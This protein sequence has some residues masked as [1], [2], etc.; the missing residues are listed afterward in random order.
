MDV[1]DNFAVDPITV[2]TVGLLVSHFCDTNMKS[3][4]SV[5]PY[6]VMRGNH[7]VYGKLNNGSLSESSIAAKKFLK[8]L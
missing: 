1:E 5:K 7:W 2:L 3:T 8:N 4:L 6:S